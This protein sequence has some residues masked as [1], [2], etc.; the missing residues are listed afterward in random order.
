M[1]LVLSLSGRDIRNCTIGRDHDSVVF[2]ITTFDR[3]NLLKKQTVTTITRYEPITGE[4]TVIG[5]IE[6]NHF[7]SDRL[8]TPHFIPH[9]FFSVDKYLVRKKQSWY[10]VVRLQ[11]MTYSVDEKS[12]GGMRRS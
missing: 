10:V 9:T 5:E 6:R 1:P 4:S 8:R 12:E 2:K 3:G 7:K 11:E